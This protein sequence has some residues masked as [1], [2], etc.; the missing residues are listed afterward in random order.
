MDTSS[1]PYKYFSH[2]PDYYTFT[3]DRGAQYECYFIS[4]EHYFANYPHLASKVFMFGID[5]VSEPV[6]KGIDY[7]IQFTVVE[8]VANFLASQVNAVVYV[9]DPSDGRDAARFKKFKSWYFYSEHPSHQI[10][11]VTSDVDIGGMTIHSALLIHKKNPK[12]QEFIE[13]FLKLTQEEK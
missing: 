13:A 8:I 2:K 7:R 4:A 11:Q 12:R 5:L 6:M 1:Q 10:Q 9:C 3:T